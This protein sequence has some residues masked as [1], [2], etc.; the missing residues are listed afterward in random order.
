M[1]ALKKTQ[2][3]FQNQ[4]MHLRISLVSMHAYPCG[5]LATQNNVSRKHKQGKAFPPIKQA[6]QRL[7]N[8]IPDVMLPEKV[9]DTTDRNN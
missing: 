7:N 6:H 8:K 3:S 2:S 4:S 1:D 9:S 5:D